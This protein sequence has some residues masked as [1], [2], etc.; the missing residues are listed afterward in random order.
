MVTRIFDEGPH[1]VCLGD[2]YD[3]VLLWILLE[4]LRGEKAKLVDESWGMGGSQEITVKEFRIGEETLK[5]FTET[6][7]GTTL[8]GPE[9]LVERIARAVKEKLPTAP[10]SSREIKL[11]EIQWPP[12]WEPLSREASAAWDA[13]I[14]PALPGDPRY[15]YFRFRCIGRRIDGEELLFE[16]GFSDLPVVVIRSPVEAELVIREFVRLEDWLEEAGKED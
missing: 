2:E 12:G 5:V 15:H 6:Y 7:M 8:H 4:T 10:L 11:Y 1:S 3:E 9:P 14:K 13:R 16:T